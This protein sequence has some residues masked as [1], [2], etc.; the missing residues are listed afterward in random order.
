MGKNSKTFEVYLEFNL[1][2]NL[3]FDTRNTV[4]DLCNKASRLQGI[5]NTSRLLLPQTLLVLIYVYRLA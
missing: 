3:N 1:N 2:G 4:Y 5:I